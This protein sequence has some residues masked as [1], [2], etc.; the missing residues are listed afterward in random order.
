MP[1]KTQVPLL[2]LAT[3]P[4]PHLTSLLS[5]SLLTAFLIRS[6]APMLFS[7]LPI[8]PPHLCQCFPKSNPPP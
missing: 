4:P 6:D 7:S 5:H 8:G 3:P 2:P 1:Q